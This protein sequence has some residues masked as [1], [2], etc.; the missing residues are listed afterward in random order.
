MPNL[1]DIQKRI[2]SV[3]GTRQITR[4]MEMVAT[5]K[6]RRAQE[7]IES[8]AP[9]SDAMMSVLANVAGNAQG[10]AHPLLEEHESIQRVIMIVAVSDRGL[11]GGFN[12]NVLRMAERQIADYQAEGLTVDLIVSG[13]RALQYFTYR[14]MQPI[15]RYIDTSDKPTYAMAREIAQ[16]TAHAFVNGEA[17]LVTIAYNR[18]KNVAEQIP[19][20]V[21][22]LPISQDVVDVAEEDAEDAAQAGYLFEPSAAEVLQR[23]LPTYLETV[24]FRALLDSAAAEQGARRRAMKSATDNATEMIGSLTRSFNRARQA[25]IT[26]EI[27]EIVGGAAALE[28]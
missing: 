21:Q 17:D 14:G 15:A 28:D 9:Y 11:A 10:I 5:A 23:L 8:A 19:T 22:V 3:Q 4:T 13:K 6:I 26:T 25:A 20:T 18:F 2:T 12:A 1:R 16:M 7:R 27:A 24:I